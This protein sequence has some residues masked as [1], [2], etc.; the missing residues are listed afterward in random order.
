MKELA[1]FQRAVDSTLEYLRAELA[2]IHTGRPSASLVEGIEIDYQGTRLPL[3]QLASITVPDSS[4]ILITPWERSNL[5]PIEQAIRERSS[6]LSAVNTG[7]IIRVQVPPLSE[8]RRLEYKRLAEQQVEEAKV[9]LRRH[10][11]EALSALKKRVSTENLSEDEEGR[12]EERLTKDTA[13]ASSNAETLGEK[14]REELS[15][16]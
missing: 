7:E 14:K 12:V 2:K 11:H 6:S 4:S 9:S 16:L 10:R 8:E 15:R 13:T 1:D 5:S 3:R